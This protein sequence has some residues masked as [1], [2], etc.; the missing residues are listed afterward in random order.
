MDINDLRNYDFFILNYREHTS[1]AINVIKEN[2]FEGITFYKTNLGWS[3]N[4]TKIG[5][6]F[7]AND[8]QNLDFTG[9][10]EVA[11]DNADQTK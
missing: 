11:M 10:F 3:L 9:N 2:H 4:P 6:G 8:K 1:I 5:R 7:I